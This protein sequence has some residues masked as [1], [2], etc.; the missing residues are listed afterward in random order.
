MV[1]E[2]DFRY[3]G[4]IPSTEESAVVMLADC[5]E[6]ATRT[7]KNPNHQKYDK[8]ISLII[9]DKMNHKQL[10]NSELTI[11]DLEKIKESFIHYL[12][13]RDHQRIEYDKE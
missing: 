12:L 4:R 13:G 2:E 11:N 8:F 7:M 1:S 5:T 3:N 6:A 10:N 9:I